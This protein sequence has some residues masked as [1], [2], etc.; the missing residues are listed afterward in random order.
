MGD[1]HRQPASAH[2]QRIGRGAAF[3][4]QNWLGDLRARARP[5]A[6]DDPHGYF[7]L[8]GVQKDHG[9]VARLQLAEGDIALAVG[10]LYDL[11]LARWS[12]RRR[13]FVGGPDWFG[14]RRFVKFPQS[15]LETHVFAAA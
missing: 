3:A 10:P 7:Q 12:G 4:R 13:Q 15:D 9:I 2:V 6:D 8:R 5:C 1:L 14:L 11:R